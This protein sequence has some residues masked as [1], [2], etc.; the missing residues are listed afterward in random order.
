MKF[1]A[2]MPHTDKELSRQLLSEGWK[3]IKEPDTFLYAVLFSLPFAFICGG[4]TFLFLYWISPSLWNFISDKNGFEISIQINLITI[5]YII[6]IFVFMLFHELIHV[7]LIP[8][9]FKSN[10]T[11]Y[12]ISFAFGFVFTTEIIKKDRYILISVMPYIILSIVLPLILET[13]GLLNVYIVLLC[14]INAIGA[15]VDFLN[16]CRVLIQVPNGASIINN[17]FETFYKK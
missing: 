1:V 11:L 6:G 4:V 17:G 9:V 14:I 10:K 3:K 2:K 16:A 5:F 8:N 15:C 12:G 13:I 7:L